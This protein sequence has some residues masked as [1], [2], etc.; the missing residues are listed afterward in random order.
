MAVAT[1][2]DRETQ[3]AEALATVSRGFKD[4]YDEIVQT[5]DKSDHV[6]KVVFE[7]CFKVQQRVVPK[8]FTA[9]ERNESIRVEFAPPDMAEAS[10]RICCA[11]LNTMYSDFSRRNAQKYVTASDFAFKASLYGSDGS[12]LQDRVL[13]DEHGRLENKVIVPFMRKK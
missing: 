12:L 13:L 3:Q 5:L 7:V 11:F 4:F 1:S 6:A 2:V 8:I 10:S 9:A